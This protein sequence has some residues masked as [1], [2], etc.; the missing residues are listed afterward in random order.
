MIYYGSESLSS[1]TTR[2]WELMPNFIKNVVSYRIKKI[3]SKYEQP[4]NIHVDF[5][6]NILA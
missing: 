3:K 2:I 5:V 4:T 1:L 6:R